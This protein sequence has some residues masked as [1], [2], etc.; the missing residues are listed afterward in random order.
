MGGYTLVLRRRH[1]I[2]PPIIQ[3]LRILR[4]F[5]TDRPG[6]V[7]AAVVFLVMGGGYVVWLRRQSRLTV[8]DQYGVIPEWEGRAIRSHLPIF[9]LMALAMVGLGLFGPV[10]VALPGAIVVY[11][12]TFAL[13]HRW[14]TAS[15]GEG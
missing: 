14:F 4:G 6:L 10:A 12:G 13:L 8:T 15:Y 9:V 3:G 1:L 5:R 7:A 11:G 2:V